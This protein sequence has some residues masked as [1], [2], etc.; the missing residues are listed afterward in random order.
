MKIRSIGSR[1]SREMLNARG[2]LGSYRPV[3][4]LLTVWR[5]TRSRPASSAWDQPFS[6]RSSLTRLSTSLSAGECSRHR[7][8]H[9]EYTYAHPQN[10]NIDSP[11]MSQGG[12]YTPAWSN[13]PNTKVRESE[14]MNAMNTDSKQ[15]RCCI[16]SMR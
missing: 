14:Q 16:S 12:W 11:T 8:F 4:M 3:S 13:P 6:P 1:N 10:T 9:P 2:R 7:Y 5:D 15:M